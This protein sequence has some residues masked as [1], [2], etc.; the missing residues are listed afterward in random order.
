MRQGLVLKDTT[1]M[2]IRKVEVTPE[3]WSNPLLSIDDIQFMINSV[4][5]RQSK[6]SDELMCRLIEERGIGKNL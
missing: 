5:E 6:S 4:L 2:I 3:V 1:S